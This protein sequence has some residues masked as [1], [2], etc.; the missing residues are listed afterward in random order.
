VIYDAV[1]LA[2]EW[3]KGQSL[4]IGIWIYHRLLSV[5]SREKALRSIAELEKKKLENKIEVDKKNSTKSDADIVNDAISEGR[6][7]SDS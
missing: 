4:A 6:Q 1:K 5:I 7:S 2:L 3:L